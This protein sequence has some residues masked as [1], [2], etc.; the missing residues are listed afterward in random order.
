MQKVWRVLEL[1]HIS[2]PYP[3][4]TF[5]KIDRARSPASLPVHL[6][7]VGCH[8]SEK[9]LIDCAHHDYTSSDPSIDISISC[10]SSNSGESSSSNDSVSIAALSIA[11]LFASAFIV[12][13]IVLIFR[14]RTKR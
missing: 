13:V 1:S 8:G 5:T 3:G 14:L 12:L 4:V 6:T 11:V 2:V 10:I 7:A 9:Q